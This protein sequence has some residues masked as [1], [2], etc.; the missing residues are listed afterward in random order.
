MAKYLFQTASMSGPGR[1]CTYFP[2]GGTPRWIYP[3]EV[4]DDSD[5]NDHFKWWLGTAVVN[6][7]AVLL[8]EPVK[9]KKKEG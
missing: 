9:A 2:D 6:G 7:C 5:A 3:G 1:S 4:I 8:D